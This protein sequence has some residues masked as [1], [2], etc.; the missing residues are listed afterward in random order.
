MG[1]PEIPR[2]VKLI[3]AVTFQNDEQLRAVEDYLTEHFGEVDV[4]S[5][6]YDFLYTD[7]Y[8]SEMGKNLKKVFLSFERLI[9]RENFPSIKLFTNQ[10]E[11]ALS[12]SGQRTENIDPGY[13]CEAS[14]IL[15]TTKNFS[16]RIYI[17][18]GIY[19]DCHLIFENDAF[20]PLPWTYP[21]YREPD[22]LNFFKRVRERYFEQLHVQKPKVSLT[23]KDAG[24][25]I[26]EGD[27]AVDNIRAMVKRTYGE[28]VLTELGKFGGFYALKKE[29]FAEPVLIS[30]VD[31]VGT[32]LK[33]AFA[34]G[35]H[36]TIGQCLVNHC[37]NDVLCCGA[38]PLFFLDYLA[39]AKLDVSV[40]TEIVFG[41]SEACADANC[42]LIGGETAEMPGFYREGEYDISGTIVGIAD[43]SKII[44]GTRIAAGDILIG[45]PS[46]G[47]HTN[48]YSLARKVFFEIAK[49][50]VYTRLPE[51]E[52]TLGEELLKVHRCYFNE[53]YPLIQQ[54]LING[55]A[56]ITGGGMVGNISRLLSPGLRVEIGWSSWEWLPIFSVIQKL[57]NI[58]DEEMRRVFNLGIGMV[59][60]ASE[61]NADTILQKLRAK[62][63]N[64]HII[65]SIGKRRS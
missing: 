23:Y 2:E 46:T 60:I 28:N 15:A 53:V 48:G 29:E 8:E 13:I 44:D 54:G 61:K 22:A 3:V 14:L 43:K 25:D 52:G 34:M 9:N 17:G 59:I 24:V 5:A 63:V 18:S 11:K 64:L 7:Y 21:D 30:S 47:L 1:M 27:R 6:V 35:V 42:A 50:S 4:R 55:L 31:G 32:K 26:T 62:Q 51:L 41:L 16:H 36:N 56:H 38:K 19:G 12:V 40:F 39:F 57:G 33:I 58:S 45:L 10:Y 65:G 49:Y 37:V 20:K